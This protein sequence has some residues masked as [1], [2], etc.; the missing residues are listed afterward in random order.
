MNTEYCMMLNWMDVHIPGRMNQ[1]ECDLCVAIHP[2]SQYS[3]VGLMW[4][5]CRIE[6]HSHVADHDLMRVEAMLEQ[7][8]MVW[9]AVVLLLF[10]WEQ[11]VQTKSITFNQHNCECE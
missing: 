3:H 6:L 1:V 4:L 5:Q 9:S 2:Q 7:D 10:V 11:Q 8:T